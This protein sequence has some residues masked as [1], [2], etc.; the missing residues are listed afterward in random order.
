[1][2]RFADAD[3]R[4]AQPPI[5][6]KLNPVT[7]AYEFESGEKFHHGAKRKNER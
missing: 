6:M 2:D 3:W 4:A 5:D 7:S 1:M